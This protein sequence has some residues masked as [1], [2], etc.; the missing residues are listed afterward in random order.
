MSKTT[1][2]LAALWVVLLL[3]PAGDAVAQRRRG[4]VDVSPSS[5]RRGAWLSLG[6]G[7]GSETYR[8]TNQPG[9]YADYVTAP[10]FW[11]AAGGTVSP[12]FR[13]GG[14][15]NGWVNEY[16]DLATGFHT[17]ES[18]VS[19]LLTGQL[20]PARRLGLFLKGGL[21]ISRS[22]TSVEGDQV[23]ETGFAWL[24]GAGWDIK[25]GRRVFL[26]PALSVLNHR[27][28]PGQRNPADDLGAL[29]ERVITVGVALTFQLGR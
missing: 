15:I 1:K 9:G 7:A 12:S 23:G 27:S 5:E 11:L 8:Y 24:G 25:L 19:G 14:E 26:S 21:G 20:Y 16:D 2:T 3:I 22:G 13:L 4:L 18:L 17:T 10:S 6:L 28:N 29:H